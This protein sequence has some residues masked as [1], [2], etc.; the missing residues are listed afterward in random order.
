MLSADLNLILDELGQMGKG[1]LGPVS[2]IEVASPLFCHP[3]HYSIL[4]RMAEKHLCLM[5]PSPA[6]CE[7]IYSSL[8]GIL[9]DA[10]EFTA[11]CTEV[12]RL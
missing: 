7:G 8:N 10:T 12:L 4:L 6:P 1:R 2:L 5:F 3:W 9:N 11:L